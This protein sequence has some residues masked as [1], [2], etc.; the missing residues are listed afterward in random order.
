MAPNEVMAHSN[1]Q[2]P[3]RKTLQ[4][5]VRKLTASLVPL[6]EAEQ[7]SAEATETG[8]VPVR[9]HVSNR[10]LPSNPDGFHCRKKA[11]I[12]YTVLGKVLGLYTCAGFEKNRPRASHHI[13]RWSPGILRRRCSGRLCT[14]RFRRGT[15]LRSHTCD[16][17]STWELSEESRSFRYIFQRCKDGSQCNF[18]SVCFCFGNWTD[19]STYHKLRA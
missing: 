11:S 3:V 8:G 19:M 18:N 13:C 16:P 1:K 14:E 4:K 17:V 10:A 9:A 6:F 12:E 2:T 15:R 5:Y 7:T